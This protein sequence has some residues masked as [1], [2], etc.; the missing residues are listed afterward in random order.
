M[1]DFAYPMMFPLMDGEA[2]GID[3]I[4]S[5]GN[6]FDGAG[7]ICSPNNVFEVR[8][9]NLGFDPTAMVGGVVGAV[10]GIMQTIAATKIAKKQAKIQEAALK[11][12]KEQN[13]REFAM[14]QVQMKAS[15]I[16]SAEERTR[17]GTY[18]IAGTLGAIGLIFVFSAI[19]TAAKR[20]DAK[21]KG[22]V[23]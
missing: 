12:Q 15:A 10:G 1:E 9:V 22:E 2:A 21:L 23:K 13:A 7:E 19:R 20:R 8:Q 4:C 6:V 18:A 5:R 16:E 3:E 17:L 11:A 14:A